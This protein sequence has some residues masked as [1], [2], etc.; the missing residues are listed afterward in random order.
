MF[1]FPKF[2][3]TLMVSD[4]TIHKAFKINKTLLN[5]PIKEMVYSH[6]LSKLYFG[7]DPRH[8]ITRVCG[9]QYLCLSS[10]NPFP[11]KEFPSFPSLKT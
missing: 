10:I 8:I 5:K 7:F 3:K 4:N 1:V 2:L 6:Y 9:F 11:N